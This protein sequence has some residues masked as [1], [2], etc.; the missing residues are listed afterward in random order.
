[1]LDTTIIII[2]FIFVLLLGLRKGINIKTISE[3][4]IADRTYA[5]PIMVA[6]IAATWFGG[7]STFGFTSSIFTHGLIILLVSMGDPLNLIIAARFLV[8]RTE[9]FENHVSV[10]EIIGSYYG[11]WPRI[12]T[13]IC[14]ALCCA[15]T[16]G[17]QV[18]ALGIIANYFLDMPYILGVILGCG[19]V[20]LYAA[21]GG[22]KAVTSTDVVQFLVIIVAMPMVCNVG[23]NQIGGFSAF[24]DKIPPDL[25]ALPSEPP[26]IINYFFL[27]LAYAVPFLDPAIMQRLLMAKNPA[28]RKSML[29]IGGLVAVPLYCIIGILGFLAIV[30]NPGTDANL[31]FAQ[32]LNDTLPAGLKGLAVIGLFSVVMSTA[33]SYLNA[34]GICLVHDTIKPLYEKRA[35]SERQELFIT[36]ITT[37]ALGIF[38][39][40]VALSFSSIMNIILF[41]FN[42]W[43]PLVVIPLYA[44]ML[45][46][47]ASTRCFYA[48]AASGLVTFVT[49]YCF[50]E[51]HLMIASLIPG[52]IGNI[53]GFCTMYQLEKRTRNR[54]TFA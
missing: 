35:L 24:I 49:W 51:P 2:Y 23:L 1:M 12:I 15:A 19:I 50:V 48:G 33:D 13:G 42:F 39:T 52:L 41:S 53:I 54:V 25:L 16:V 45:G 38:A 36:K 4:A 20:I 28:Q 27:F 43:G 34:A 40:I 47:N 32:L 10:G 21:F 14:G 3:Y 22:I 6:T 30:N 17:G 7:G 26:A 37:F 9:I 8:K 46:Y 29:V 18:S 31:S 44:V 5:L 11:R